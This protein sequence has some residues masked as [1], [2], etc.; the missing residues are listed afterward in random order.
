VVHTCDEQWTFSLDVLTKHNKL[1]SGPSVPPP[2]AN[3]DLQA[4]SYWRYSWFSVTMLSNWWPWPLT[5]DIGT[6]VE[7]QPWHR[8]PSCWFWYFCNLSLWSYGQICVKLTTWHYNRDLLGHCTCQRCG[9]SYSICIPSLKFVEAFPFWRYNWFSVMALI[10][11]MISISK[12]GH[13]SPVSWA[14]FLPNFR[15]LQPSI[16]N[17]GKLRDIRTD[18]RRPSMH[19]APPYG[20]GGI[21]RSSATADKLHNPFSQHATFCQVTVCSFTIS[22]NQKV[23]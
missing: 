20:G 4:F 7:C 19:Y 16:L 3:G 14:S 11:L 23:F 15:L 21:T 12:W 13:G 1:C 2:P 8:Q 9:S 10:G 17:V 5:F 18:R 22:W 6:G